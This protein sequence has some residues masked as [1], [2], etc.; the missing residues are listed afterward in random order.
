MKIL[1]ILIACILAAAVLGLIVGLRIL[2]AAMITAISSWKLPEDP[3]PTNIIP[4]NREKT[5]CNYPE[6]YCPLDAPYDPDDTWCAIGLPKEQ[7][8]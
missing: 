7:R 4:I 2:S 3:Q 8:S 1:L 5:H 6:C